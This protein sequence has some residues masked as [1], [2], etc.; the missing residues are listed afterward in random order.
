[1]LRSRLR[2]HHDSRDVDFEHA[3]CI[4]SSV[5]QRSRLLL[6]AGRSNQPVKSTLLV[7]DFLN[8][9]MELL[10][11]SH[12]YLAVFERSSEFVLC[13]LSNWRKVC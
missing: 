7:G 13:F 9:L 4:L 1:L 3:V 10:D 5:F 6:D 2:S 12:V 8:N 11:I